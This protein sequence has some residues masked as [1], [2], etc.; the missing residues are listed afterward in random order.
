MYHNIIVMV[1]CLHGKHVII[2]VI[3]VRNKNRK[4][5]DREIQKFTLNLH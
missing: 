1:S 3:Y 4:E 2:Y 5:R